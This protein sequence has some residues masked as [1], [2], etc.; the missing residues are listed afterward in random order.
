M[1]KRQVRWSKLNLFYIEKLTIRRVQ[2]LNNYIREL[3]CN[4]DLSF[5]ENLEWMAV[6]K[7][8]LRTI[9]FSSDF[10]PVRWRWCSF[11]LA[12]ADQV[13]KTY[14]LAGCNTIQ[15][16]AMYRMQWSAIQCKTIT[17]LQYITTQYINTEY[18][19][20][21]FSIIACNTVQ[22]NTVQ[23]IIVLQY[24][25]T[26]YKGCPKK[27]SFLKKARCCLKG[28]RLSQRTQTLRD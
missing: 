11:T 23:T 2:R 16:K 18:E 5:I 15:P 24:N 12:H 26:Q 20:S 25:A 21:A 10:Y 13:M 14:P 6:L 22:Y 27:P 19:I 1:Y 8:E 4:N 7:L 17:V 28:N 3:F 9:G